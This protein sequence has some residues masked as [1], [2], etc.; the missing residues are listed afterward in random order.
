ML[1]LITM[2]FHIWGL[3]AY[4]IFLVKIFVAQSIV[5]FRQGLKYIKEF[6]ICLLAF[7]KNECN[8]T[9]WTRAVGTWWVHGTRSCTVAGDDILPPDAQSHKD[10]IVPSTV[11][12]RVCISLLYRRRFSCILLPMHTTINALS[13]SRRLL[14]ILLRRM[15]TRANLLFAI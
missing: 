15:H 10:V 1:P 5:F 12:M 13:R 2:N 14:C 3:Y 9:A 11:N 6:N 7:V 8:I 4:G